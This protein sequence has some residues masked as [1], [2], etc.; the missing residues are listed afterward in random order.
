MLYTALMFTH[1]LMGES[2]EDQ[3]RLNQESHLPSLDAATGQGTLSNREP[4]QRGP[5]RHGLQFR[6][7]NPGKALC[8]SD[9]LLCQGAVGVLLLGCR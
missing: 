7:R 6:L 8:W 4:E 5:A 3:S 1:L 9:K 2:L